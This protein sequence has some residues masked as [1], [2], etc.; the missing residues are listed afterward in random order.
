MECKTC[1]EEGIP[2]EHLLPQSTNDMDRIN[3]DPEMPR[4]LEDTILAR[5]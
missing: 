2:A 5:S 3:P 1:P 4:D